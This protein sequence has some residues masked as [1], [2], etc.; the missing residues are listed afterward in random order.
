MGEWFYRKKSVEAELKLA[1]EVDSL[2][3]KT[4]TR[5]YSGK[6]AVIFRGV[7]SFADKAL[8]AQEAGAVAIIIVNH[9]KQADGT[10]NGDEIFAMAGGSSY[11]DGTS[12]TK[13]KIPVIMISKNTY[14]TLSPVLRSVE[15]VLG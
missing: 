5:D 3:D 9:G 6:I 14:L 4:L 13:V 7:A 1:T 15:T 12:G 10:V 11:T 8:R 2:A